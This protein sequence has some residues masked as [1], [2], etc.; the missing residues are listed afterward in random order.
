MRV[1]AFEFPGEYADER[2]SQPITWRAE[3][4]RKLRGRGLRGFELHTDIRGVEFWG[5][6]FDGLEPIE[7]ARPDGLG[8]QFDGPDLSHCSLSGE[9]PCVIESDGARRPLTVHFQ[10][11]LPP[12]DPHRPQNLHL[13]VELEGA[14][15]AVTHEWFE[16][17]LQRLSDSLPTD[18]RLICC[19]TCLYSDY[20]PGGHGLTGMAC[21]RGAKEQYL[22]V[23]SKADYW[24]VPVAELVMETYVCDEYELRRPGT[25]YR[26]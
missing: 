2:G 14:R 5:Y 19:V 11:D 23:R 18:H 15:V 7:S 16:D 13:S 12:E 1:E 21:H 8:F 24:S 6:D 9:L 22:A 4:S 10:L 20:S 25:G 3:P 17:G 26:G